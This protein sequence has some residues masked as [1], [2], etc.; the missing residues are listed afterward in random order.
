M[1]K[2][3]PQPRFRSAGGLAA[4]APRSPHGAR[5][6]HAKKGE[7]E[8]EEEEEEEGQAP[9][10][11]RGLAICVLPL[12][13]PTR[14]QVLESHA[15]AAGARV[16]D[17]VAALQAKFSNVT[18]L[19]VDVARDEALADEALLLT[20]V[21]RFVAQQRLPGLGALQAFPKTAPADGFF[22][23]DRTW[24]TGSKLS[25]NRKAETDCVVPRS[26]RSANPVSDAS[27]GAAP[28]PLS[29]VP[30]A[31]SA[32]ASASPV[33]ARATS[34]AS[35]YSD[36]EEGDE[37]ERSYRSSSST[38]PSGVHARANAPD[39][40]YL[41][42]GRVSVSRPDV[43]PIPLERDEHGAPV[44][45]FDLSKELCTIPVV[46]G[47]FN[48]A[49]RAVYE[50]RVKFSKARPQSSPRITRPACSNLPARPCRAP[51]VAA[52][53]YFAGCKATALRQVHW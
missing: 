26:A 40:P 42:F 47:P 3:H 28:V 45:P 36:D 24:L 50:R 9:Q 25:R 22:V 5:Q 12:G 6:R 27:A 21:N 8:E 52:P 44:P 46:E 7:E 19:V 14:A 10:P 53:N 38:S 1:P 43:Q 17:P 37:D 29:P 31:V 49:L 32:S 35:R 30:A 33:L 51:R 16:V 34:T 48:L 18:H 15:V 13:S 4:A 11:L 41:K 2:S 20:L 39:H 23:V